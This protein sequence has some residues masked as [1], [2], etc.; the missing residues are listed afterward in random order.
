V[1]LLP[2]S[3]LLLTSL[4]CSAAEAL[5]SIEPSSEVLR[6]TRNFRIFLPAIR[7]MVRLPVIYWFTLREATTFR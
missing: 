6:E 1:F 7:R 5:I 4:G 2:S 3:R